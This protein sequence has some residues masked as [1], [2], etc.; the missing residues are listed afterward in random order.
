MATKL[1]NYIKEERRKKV[2]SQKSLAKKAGVSEKTVGRIEREARNIEVKTLKKISKALDL[3]LFDVL[4]DGGL[5][6]EKDLKN[7]LVDGH[8]PPATFSSNI[9]YKGDK[10]LR[11][12]KLRRKPLKKEDREFIDKI[13]KKIKEEN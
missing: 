2:L 13:T 11:N 6:S 10:A 9:S 4:V 1:G 5:L 3:D 12:H 7:A 8:K